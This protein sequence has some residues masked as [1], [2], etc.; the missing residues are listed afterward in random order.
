MAQT[1]YTPIL[2]YGS[3][4]ATN[5]PTAGNLTS[6]TSGAELAINYADGKLFYK[7]GA[8][9]VQ[10]LATKAATSGTFSNVAITGGSITGVSLGTV[11]GN[12]IFSSTGAITL[13]VG[14]T[15]QQPTASAGM[16]R[17]NS[18]TTQF[19]GYNGSSW[20][21][22][23][24][25]AISNDTTT[26]TAVYPLFASSTSGTALTVYTSNAKLLYTPSTG[27]LASTVFSGAGTGL[28]GTAASLSIGGTAANIAAGAANQI[29]YQTSANTT[30]FIAA[31]T[32]TGNALT[33]NGTNIVW[34][35]PSN[36]AASYTRT[37]ITASGGQTV[38]TVSY[39]V[40][41]V[42]VFL[43]GVLLNAADYTA[44]NGTSVTLTTAAG[45]GDIVEFIA[46]ATGTLIQLP[47]NLATS[48][49][50]TLPVANG[51]T[52]ITTTPSNGQIPIGNGTNY[53]AA[54]LTAGAGIGITNASGAITVAATG[55]TINSQ[56]TGYTLVAGDAGKTISIT[57][58]GVTIPNSVMSAGN[59]V[60]VYNNSGSSQTITQGTG[61]TLQWAGQTSSTTGNR[62]LGLYGM[63]TIIYITASNAVISGSGLT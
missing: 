54:T 55:S 11:T 29:P 18:T 37:S 9:I 50:G 42:E 62:T 35:T 43:N 17:F 61:V 33:W 3:G 38:F 28:T 16:L 30:S 45:A 52:G 44:S 6:N 12:P 63:A 53:T 22:V 34:G 60:N 57:T 1:G 46:Y 58:G 15:G 24:G 19:E 14:T 26:A 51:G 21:S 20:S 7:D 41:Y 40:G 4:T 10:V 27:T 49:T 31:P 56:T 47:I 23:G 59:I 36:T 32:V 25:A 13:P 48:V 8:G 2:I 5:V 39:T